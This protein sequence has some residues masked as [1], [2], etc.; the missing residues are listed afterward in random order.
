MRR[1]GTS[2]T[3]SSFLR[4]EKKFTASRLCRLLAL[5]LVPGRALVQCLAVRPISQRLRL[6]QADKEDPSIRSRLSG[7]ESV[8]VIYSASLS[9]LPAGS[10]SVARV[11]L[12]VQ[13]SRDPL[14]NSHA[15]RD[16]HTFTGVVGR[17]DKATYIACDVRLASE[18]VSNSERVRI[19]QRF[20]RSTCG[21]KP[22][23]V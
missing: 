8:L 5:A 20:P 16:C 21:H 10:P 19:N 22:P 9:V 23:P 17:L 11:L 14:I 6:L 12:H 18:R 4:S 13:T 7:P 15:L 1:S 3:C 2:S